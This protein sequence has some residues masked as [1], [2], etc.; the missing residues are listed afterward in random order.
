LFSFVSIYFSFAY[1]IGMNE[2]LITL[3]G[4]RY[5]FQFWRRANLNRYKCVHARFPPPQRM[6]P[7]NFSSMLESL[8]HLRNFLTSSNKTLLFLIHLKDIDDGAVHFC[9][10]FILTL[11]IVQFNKIH[12]VSE[13]GSVSVFR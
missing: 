8:P 2:T 10:L 4:V 6:N 9:I 11:S 13:T 7:A 5:L 3:Y 1:H 12:N